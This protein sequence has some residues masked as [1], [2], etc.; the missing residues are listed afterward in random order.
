[1]EG[2]RPCLP[3]GDAAEGLALGLDGGLA[4]EGDAWATVW[5]SPL[6]VATEPPAPELDLLVKVA[7]LAAPLE[8]E[9]PV[10]LLVMVATV[11]FPDPAGTTRMGLVDL[12]TTRSWA[13]RACWAMARCAWPQA[14]MSAT[15]ARQSVRTVRRLSAMIPSCPSGASLRVNHRIDVGVPPGAAAKRWRR[16]V[17]QCS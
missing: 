1:M 11:D 2:L 7:T 12:G 17:A 8:R 15:V 14:R 13:A 10:A 6:N 9:G 5:R 4:R 3:V 16:W